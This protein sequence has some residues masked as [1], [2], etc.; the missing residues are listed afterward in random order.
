MAV[1]LAQAI[2]E[3]VGLLFRMG[4]EAAEDLCRGVPDAGQGDDDS[5]GVGD[6]CDVCTAIADP[7]QFDRDLDGYGNACDCDFDNNGSCNI[8]DFSAFLAD[9]QTQTDSGSGTDMNVDGIVGIEDFGLFL[10]GFQAGLPGPSGLA[11]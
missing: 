3:D 10:S 4:A 2:G 5:D 6:A 8:E 7:A 1:H 9:F 11:Q